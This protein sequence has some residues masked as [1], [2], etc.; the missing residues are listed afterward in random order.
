MSN[1]SRFLIA[2][3]LPAALLLTPGCG[4]SG[5]DICD[6]FCD[7]EGCTEHEYDDCLHTVDRDLADAERRGCTDLYD[8]LV[9][10]EDATGTCRGKDWDS[11]CGHEHDDLK[12]CID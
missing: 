7:C 2:A 4:T 9:A 6:N 10:C 11:S 12:H 8:E 5:A 1:P 3:L